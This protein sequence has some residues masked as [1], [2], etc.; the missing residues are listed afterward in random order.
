MRKITINA[1]YDSP[2]LCLDLMREIPVQE[3][4]LRT[5][6]A[7]LN[8]TEQNTCEFRVSDRSHLLV[9]AQLHGTFNA[10]TSTED[11]VYPQ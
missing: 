10:T 2:S 8:Y 1:I 7:T 3:T 9:T 5:T 6:T 11:V 4:E